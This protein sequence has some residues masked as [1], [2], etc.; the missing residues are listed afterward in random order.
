MKSSD[1]LHTFKRL[2]AAR[3]TDAATLAVAQGFDA[4]FEF[5]RNE[6]ADDCEIENDGDMLLFQWGTYGERNA[7]RFELD[8]T[9]QFIR[10]EGEDDDI[11]QLSLTFVF[12]PNEIPS[13][14]SWCGAPP[15]LDSFAEFV[16]SHAAYAAV[17]HD[18]PVLVELDYECAG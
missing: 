17:A 2:L 18:T 3:G 12:P 6:R 5:Y 8:I 9:R 15:D 10:P 1:A 4:M 7:R 13:G 16:R 11:W 14:D